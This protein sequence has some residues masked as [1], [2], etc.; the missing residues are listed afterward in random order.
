MVFPFSTIFNEKALDLLRRI[1][2]A[3]WQHL[4]FLGHYAFRDK[5]KPIDLQAVLD[6]ID[7]GEHADPHRF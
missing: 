4:H 7:L 6:G 2:P 3:A 1:S 5:R